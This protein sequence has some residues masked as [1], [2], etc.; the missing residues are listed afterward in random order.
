M[1][2]CV[3]VARQVWVSVNQPLP[4]ATKNRLEQIRWMDGWMDQ[5][6]RQ[7][8]LLILPLATVITFLPFL[9]LALRTI[10]CMQMTTTLESSQDRKTAE[11]GT[12]AV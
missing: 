6:D 4:W 2:L 12:L 5:T 8:Y 3:H 11:A 10:L 7:T 1:A 9:R